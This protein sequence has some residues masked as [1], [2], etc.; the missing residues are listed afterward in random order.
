MQ[1][2]TTDNSAVFET[3][4]DLYKLVASNHIKSTQ[5]WLSVLMR[6]DTPDTRTRDALLK[7]V[8][9]LRTQ[10]LDSLAKCESLGIDRTD[11]TSASRSE[12]DDADIIWEEGDLETEKLLDE[13][14]STSHAVSTERGEDLFDLVFKEIPILWSSGTRVIFTFCSLYGHT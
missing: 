9:D 7:D 8:I 5:E 1:K 4:R 2:E 6:V 11:I 10:L 12:I 13:T 3:L 14:A